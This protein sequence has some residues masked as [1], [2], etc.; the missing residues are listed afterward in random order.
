MFARC[1]ALTFVASLLLATASVA[2][3]VEPGSPLV[4]PPAPRPRAA[5]AAEPAVRRTSLPRFL[6]S[7]GREDGR[8]KL[9][10]RF[11]REAR[12][13]EEGARDFLET[14]S[15][16]V[17]NAPGDVI[18][19][20]EHVQIDAES[21]SAEQE[22]EALVDAREELLAELGKADPDRA[23][24]GGER[25]PPWSPDGTLDREALVGLGFART[26]RSGPLSPDVDRL[27]GRLGGVERRLGAV[28]QQ[29]LPASEEALGTALLAL[30]SGEATMLE[31]IHGLHFLKHQ[32]RMRLELRVHRELLLLELARQLGCRVDQ[33]PWV[34]SQV[35]G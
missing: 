10:L 13:I 9:W 33:L 29:L 30:A 1:A 16:L 15:Q 31:V 7:P 34:S 35:T 20:H 23:I 8:V 21:L 18:F 25:A 32:Q 27:L 14:L 5:P 17:A 4:V 26:G 12:L 28:E 11:N 6:E 24:L 2:S 3:G 19:S 22:I